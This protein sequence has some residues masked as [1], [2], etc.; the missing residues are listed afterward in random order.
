MRDKKIKIQEFENIYELHRDS[1]FRTCLLFLKDY[2]LAEDAAQET[3]Y[4][5]YCK[6]HTFGGKSDIKTWITRISVNVCKDKMRKKSFKEQPTEERIFSNLPFNESEI[7]DKLIV[8]RA[9]SE[10]PIDLREVTVLFY[11]Q[12]IKQKDIAKILK[13]PETTVAYRLRKAKEILRSLMKEAFDNE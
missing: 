8:V 13:I 6:L 10:L 9:I 7:E 1:V 11:Y 4:K 5:V 12:E 3:F 2:Q